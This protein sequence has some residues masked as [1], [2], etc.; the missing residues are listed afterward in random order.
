MFKALLFLKIGK[1]SNHVFQLP[2][3]QL[4]LKENLGT[5][6]WTITWLQDCLPL[7]LG[8]FA[9]LENMKSIYL[10][11]FISDK[12]CNSFGISRT[13]GIIDN[14]DVMLGQYDDLHS[15]KFTKNKLLKHHYYMVDFLYH[16]RNSGLKSIWFIDVLQISDSAFN[17]ISKNVEE[18][19]HH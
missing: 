11:K 19:W 8:Y 13:F 2:V 3:L 10:I 5:T 6:W 14:F 4:D 17:W 1:I 12:F 18:N 9:I 7:F 15:F 16:S